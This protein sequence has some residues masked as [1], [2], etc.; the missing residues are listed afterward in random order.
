MDHIFGKLK[1]EFPG[2]LLWVGMWG[3][4]DNILNKY[5]QPTDYNKRIVVFFIIMV[6]ALLLHL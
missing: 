3:L 4:V 2:L 1:S 5:M 6:L